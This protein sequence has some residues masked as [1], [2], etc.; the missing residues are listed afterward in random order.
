MLKELKIWEFILTIPDVCC[1]NDGDGPIK[2]NE[3]GGGPQ[4]S[5][6]NTVTVIV[7]LVCPK[8]ETSP[9]AR[10]KSC[11][12]PLNED[13]RSKSNTRILTDLFTIERPNFFTTI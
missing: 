12:Y 1:A 3:Y 4:L 2:T 13:A 7:P 10:E 5:S 6:V 11:P 8:Q 9:F